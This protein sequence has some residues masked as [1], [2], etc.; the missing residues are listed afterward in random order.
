MR[1]ECIRCGTVKE[2][3]PS[4][5]GQYC[6]RSCFYE[7]RRHVVQVTCNQ[8]GKTVE[9]VPSRAAL[10][11]STACR[12]AALRQTVT[13]TCAQCGTVFTARPRA[14]AAGNGRYCSR[15]CGVLA[16]T[17]PLQVRFERLVCRDVNE[18]GC[19]SSGDNRE[20]G[21]NRPKMTVS[22]RTQPVAHVSWLLYRGRIPRGKWVLHKCP[23]GENGWCINPDHLY[24]GT[25]KDNGQDRLRNGHA[26]WITKPERIRRGEQHRSAKLTTLQVE[27]IRTRYAA[28]GISQAALGAEYGVHG[29][30]IHRIVH[31]QRRALG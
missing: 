17:L 19:W 2:R 23:G 22:G 26:P 14:V 20:A 1:V 11:C 13:P 24:L 10:F 7:A 25:S 27:E 21:Q 16:R 6:S 8:C 30:A 9:R 29:P 18:A 28:G 5:A 15:S 12:D 4:G 31:Y 3:P